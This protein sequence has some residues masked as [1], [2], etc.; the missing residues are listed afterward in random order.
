MRGHE[1][2]I[3]AS[4]G[5]HLHSPR[6]NLWVNTHLA[7]S[8]C[9]KCLLS[10][11]AQGSRF[12]CLRRWVDKSHSPWRPWRR[13]CEKYVKKGFLTTFDFA[14]NRSSSFLKSRPGKRCG[15]VLVAQASLR[16]A[17][18]PCTL[19]AKMHEQL[20]SEPVSSSQ[21]PVLGFGRQLF[22]K[23]PLLSK[24]YV[25]DA[26][27]PESSGLGGSTMANNHTGVSIGALCN[28]A[29]AALLDRR[30]EVHSRCGWNEPDVEIHLEQRPQMA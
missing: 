15:D 20:I 10:S 21:I 4:F 17:N 29:Y 8:C 3:T 23:I 19:L 16:R 13:V 25:A 26:A 22:S 14:I 18:N 11:L 1:S 7:W 24:L 6:K 28:H 12:G 2:D 30:S 27:L 9:Y 5:W